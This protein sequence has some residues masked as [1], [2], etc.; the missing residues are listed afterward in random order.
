MQ[1]KIYQLTWAYFKT[2]LKTQEKEIFEEIFEEIDGKA[3][4][5][6]KISLIN[7]LWKIC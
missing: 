1:H 7:R 5:L 3:L 4:Y 2:A 6:G